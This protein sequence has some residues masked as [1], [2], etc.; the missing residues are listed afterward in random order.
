[1]EGGECRRMPVLW[2]SQSGHA[3]SSFCLGGFFLSSFVPVPASRQGLVTVMRAFFFAPLPPKRVDPDACARR[4]LLWDSSHAL[5]PG[6]MYTSVV[7]IHI[8]QH[9]GECLQQ[10]R[11][12]SHGFYRS[13]CFIAHS[14]KKAMEFT[15]DGACASSCAA[16][17]MV[18]TY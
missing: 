11:A 18:P 6:D 2:G 16:L 9:D 3:S 4:M 14:S 7:H 5:E 10:P 1:M 17:A 15:V 12:R 13:C 8:R